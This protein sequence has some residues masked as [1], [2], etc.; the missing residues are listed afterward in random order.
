MVEDRSP[1]LSMAGAGAGTVA[2]GPVTVTC[3]GGGIS[4]VAMRSGDGGGMTT[5]TGATIG[6]GVLTCFSGSG[7]CDGGGGG[8]GSGARRSSITVRLDSA[9]RGLMTFIVNRDHNNI[10]TMPIEIASA[11]ILGRRPSP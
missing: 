11:S 2:G 4:E 6:D 3:G 1:A 7:C 10:P 8:G 9:L 5:G